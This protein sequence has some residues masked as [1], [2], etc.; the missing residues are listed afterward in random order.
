MTETKYCPQCGNLLGSA[1]I[2]GRQRLV[3]SAGCGYVL[4][5]NPIPVVAGIVEYG[6]S[7]ILVR[8]K[9]WPEKFFGL[10]TGFLEKKEK[11]EEAI[12]RELQEEL[13]LVGE[14]VGFVGNYAFFQN[15]QIILAYHVHARGEIQLGEELSAYKLI[16]PDNLRPWPFGTGPAVKDWLV[17]RKPGS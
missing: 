16:R 15:N 1:D 3:C 14:I 7:V 2:A 12:L 13:G 11:P 5:D 10:V 4:W 17:R 9:D 6:D 8:N